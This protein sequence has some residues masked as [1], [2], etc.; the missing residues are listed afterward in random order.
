MTDQS[1]RGTPASV[2][3][4]LIGLPLLF[5]GGQWWLKHQTSTWNRRAAAIKELERLG[6]T[7]RPG[8]DGQIESIAV[9]GP[10][11]TDGVLHHLACF[12]D[13]LELKLSAT[14]TTNDGLAHL[15]D[16]KRLRLLYLDKTLLT[17]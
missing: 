5:F 6:A 1:S 10:E 17:G 8:F 7:M 14:P 15:Q 12:P 9:Y 3:A 11:V 4:L 13:L 2:W 16:L